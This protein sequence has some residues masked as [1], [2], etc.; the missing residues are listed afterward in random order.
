VKVLSY[1][2][3]IETAGGLVLAVVF[4]SPERM[5]RGVDDPWPVLIDRDRSVYGSWGLRRASRLRLLRPGWVLGYAQMLARGERL[6]LP[7]SDVLQLGGDFVVD[8]DGVVVLAAPQLGFDDRPP[9]GVLVKAL[10]AAAG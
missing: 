1:R 8:R 9:A 3:R 4:E 2:D 10:E 6:A 7:G 5:L